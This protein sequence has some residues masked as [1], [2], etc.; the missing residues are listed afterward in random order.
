MASKEGDNDSFFI[1]KE[2]SSEGF[3]FSN[4]V[5]NILP[6]KLPVLLGLVGLIAIGLGMIFSGSMVFGG[7]ETVEVLEATTQSE[8]ST[9]MI[10]EI[11]GAVQNPGVYEFDSGARVVDLL[12]RAGGLAGDADKTWVDKM[13]NK[14]SV[15]KD[16][17]KIYIPSVD[18]QSEIESARN[19]GGVLG[20]S[21]ES[22]AEPTT[23]LNINTASLSEL[24]A[25]WGIGPVTA[26][27]IIEQRSYSSV[28]E[29]LTRKILKQNVYDRN[30][31]LLTAF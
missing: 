18:E 12:D 5:A 25:L 11:A 10:I 22:Q 27:K 6:Y 17:Q 3:S 21:G 9:S 20:T 2:T 13:I 19:I 8:E 15:L 1:D 4:L 26:Q 23:L 24:E 28:D 31:D 30:K 7:K 16:G 29:L 14:A